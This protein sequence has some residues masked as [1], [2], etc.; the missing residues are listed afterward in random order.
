MGR[1]I[2]ER[3][4][5]MKQ[6]QSRS[7]EKETN[8]TTRSEVTHILAE[9]LDESYAKALCGKIVCSPGEIRI[10]SDPTYFRYNNP[11]CQKCLRQY[12]SRT[13]R[14]NRDHG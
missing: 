4:E 8:M 13:D 14:G 9:R 12:F 5:L 2:L 3:R 7:R 1:A 6:S 11:D 10:I